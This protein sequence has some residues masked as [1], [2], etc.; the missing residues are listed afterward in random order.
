VV[1]ARRL[2]LPIQQ[3]ASRIQQSSQRYAELSRERRA[4]KRTYVSILSL[5]TLLLLFVATWFAMFLSKQVT[6][7]VQALAEATHEVSSGNLG[8]QIAARTDDELGSLI[9]LFNRMTLQLQEGRLAIERSS[10]EVQQAN[11]ELEERSHTMEAILE[12]IPTGVIS[13]N[14]QGQIT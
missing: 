10:Q 2:P 13:L 1:T 11:R 4:L 3:I 12:N 7:P 9:H 8:F 5:L 6:G 14:R